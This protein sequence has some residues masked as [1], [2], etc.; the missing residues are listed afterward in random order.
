MQEGD[1]VYANDGAERVFI[2]NTTFTPL[3][4]GTASVRLN[5]AS[6]CE[7]YPC[8]ASNG[9]DVGFG[10]SYCNFSLF[11]TPCAVGSVSTDGRTCAIGSNCVGTWSTCSSD[12]R[13]DW[14]QTAAPSGAGAACPAAPRCAA[15]EDDCPDIALFAVVVVLFVCCIGGCLCALLHMRRAKAS[16][17]PAQP[18]LSMQEEAPLLSLS[19]GKVHGP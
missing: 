3:E 10:C 8:Q 9:S 18:F 6:G 13:R 15:G 5:Q 19:R 7:Q 12:C 16:G 2:L 11:C 14:T 17:Q 1:H 4:A